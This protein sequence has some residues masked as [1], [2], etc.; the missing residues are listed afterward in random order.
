MTD[1]L[2][3]AAARITNNLY[4][5]DKYPNVVYGKWINPDWLH[6]FLWNR[7]FFV[8]R[9][10][11]TSSTAHN[12]WRPSR[13][14][15][16]FPSVFYSLL[17][18]WPSYSKSYH[19]FPFL[20]RWHSDICVVKTLLAAKLLTTVTSFWLSKRRQLSRCE[21]VEFSHVSIRSFLKRGQ[22]NK[23]LIFKM[24]FIPSLFL[25]WW[26]KLFLLQYQSGLPP[27]CIVYTSK[28]RCLT[29]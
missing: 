23:L 1:K 8:V 9:G 5:E 16:W 14:R 18:S 21:R 20:C 2:E 11:S 24:T 17:P 13:L 4:I 10:N 29:H 3:H 7:T 15:S 25:F 27:L 28:R 12:M 22:F 6:S 19:L 26:L